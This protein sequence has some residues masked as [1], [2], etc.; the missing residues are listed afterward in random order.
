[1]SLVVDAS[2]GVKWLLDEPQ[3]DL[4]ERLLADATTLIAPELFAIE[5]AS[6]LTTRLRRGAADAR[7]VDDAALQLREILATGVTMQPA[8][9]LLG[10]MIAMSRELNHSLYDCSYLALA[11]ERLMPLVTADTVFLRKL[12]GTGWAPL[13]CSLSEARELLA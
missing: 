1:M 7:L 4:T 13:A 5:V 10:R 2:I 3:S 6:V 12:A 8:A 9:H 11:E